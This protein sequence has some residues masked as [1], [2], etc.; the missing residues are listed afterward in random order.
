[1]NSK[2]S[3]TLILDGKATAQ[4][5][6]NEI[7]QKVAK[8]K[9]SGLKVPHLA[10]VLVGTDGGSE[11]YV[12]FKVKDCKE[13][14]YDSTLIR[15][16]ESVSENDLLDLVKE[17]NENEEIDGFIVQL[18]LPGHI[19]PQK[20][21]M[22]INPMKDVDGFHPENVGKMTLGLSGFL[23]ATPSGIIELMRR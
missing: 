23:P 9:Q 10:A 17:L 8:R 22:A 14:G 18:P 21:I 20:V 11:T 15:K 5:I 1:M 7:A 2:T 3:N 6:R 13:V 4:E 19:N 12:S 16:P